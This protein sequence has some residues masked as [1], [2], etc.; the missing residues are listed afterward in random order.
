MHLARGPAAASQGR[1]DRPGA[2]RIPVA[3]PT[4]LT[5]A[6]LGL[7]VWTATEHPAAGVLAALSILV[8]YGL[9]VMRGRRFHDLVAVAALM[10][11]V[12]AAV[13]ARQIWLAGIVCALCGYQGRRPPPARRL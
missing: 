1:P 2:A 10:P 8:S 3:L 13:W 12:G 11:A 4:A 5:P 7:A 6:A 9:W